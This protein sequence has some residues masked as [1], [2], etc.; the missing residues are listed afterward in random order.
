MKKINVASA[1][2]RRTRK[3]FWIL[4]LVLLVPL[5]QNCGAGFQTNE[6]NSGSLLG[7]SVTEVT[8]DSPLPDVPDTPVQKGITLSTPASPLVVGANVTVS[9]NYTLNPS[10]IRLVWMN[11]AVEVGAP[12][13]LTNF[14]G[15]TYSAILPAPASPGV[16]KIKASYEGAA[17]TA[18]TSDV[19]LTSASN[20]KLANFT[21]E[22]TGGAQ[23]LVSLYGHAFAKGTLQPTDPVVLKRSDNAQLL[24]TQMNV[25]SRWSDG[26]VK[27]VLLASEIPALASKAILP[28]ELMA[29]QA[30]PAPGANLEL[31]SQL[32]SRRAKVVVTPLSGPTWEFDVAGAALTADR[33]HQGPLAISTRLETAVPESATGGKSSVRLIVDL[34]LTSD[35]IL[36]LDVAFSNDRVLHAAGGIANFAYSIQIDGEIVY[37]QAQN[38]LLQYSQWI[39]RRAKAATGVTF[40]R[41]FFRPDMDVLAKSGVV[42]NYDRSQPIDA[43]PIKQSVTDPLAAGASKISDPYWNWGVHR[44]AGEAGGRPEIG[45]RTFATAMWLRDGGGEAV[46]LSHRQFEAASTRPIYFYDWELSRWLN[47][48]DWP[49]MGLSVAN[50]ATS[51]PGTARQDAI[52]LP[53]NQRPTHNRTDYITV[54][55]AH[56]GSFN[57][58]VALLAGRRLAYDG[59]AARS[60]WTVMDNFERANG[61]TTNSLSWRTLTPDHTTGNAWAVRPWATQT[62][63]WAWDFRDIVDCAAIL[64]DNYDNRSFYNQNVEA[65]I[66][67]FYTVM[68]EIK[69][70]FGDLGVPVI[71]T[72]GNSFP[73]YMFSFV[74]YGAISAK[75]ME[76]GGPNLDAVFGEWIKIRVGSILSEDFNYRNALTGRGIFMRGGVGPATAKTWAEVQ[77]KTEEAVGDTPADWSKNQSNGD[78]QRSVL[79]GLGLLMG[80]NLPL[81][82][83]AEVAESLVL[84]RSERVPAGAINPRL[85]PYMFFEAFFQTNSLIAPGLTWQ[86]NSAPVIRTGQSFTIDRTAKAGD[87]VGVVKTDGPIPRN[88]ASGRGV[89]DACQITSQPAGNPFRISGGGVIRRASI[90]TLSPGVQTLKVKCSTWEGQ[91][92]VR[93]ESAEGSLSVT[94]FDK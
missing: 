17:P 49:K 11:G 78:P 65:Y 23:P 68:P 86:W 66:N 52:G 9:G 42:L 55:H 46:T 37:S 88:S 80:L 84:L 87:I 69:E 19:T 30:H 18:L 21:F 27:S 50:S 76:L 56:H 3:A 40:E 44:N 4:F 47:P 59:L 48:V 81:S 38:N 22:G 89:D 74:F 31:N 92:T 51:N 67:S 72:N 2:M 90:G 33:W 45:Y 70:M 41:P 57:W 8:P 62:R 14:T 82:T 53:S 36:E 28:V 73:G 29:G 12:L 54:D 5:F 15:G 58:T 20:R 94:V 93:H 83:Q 77:A 7:L 63:S 79:S 39:R 91:T 85:D 61:L 64:P 35:G 16:Y 26:S 13:V 75:Q 24:R 10:S 71:H 43:R 32:A 1:L 6:L 60:A 34:I 25:L